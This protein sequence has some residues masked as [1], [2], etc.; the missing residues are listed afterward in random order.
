MTRGA[1]ATLR[2]APPRCPDATAPFGSVERGR[3][4]DKGGLAMTEHPNVQLMRDVYA[5]FTVGDLAKAGSYW[6]D[7]CTHH[8]P[9]RSQLAG[10]HKGVAEATAFATKLFELTGGNIQMDIVDIGASDDY[11]FAVVHTRYGRNGKTLDMPFINVARV[12]GGKIAEFWT[13]P[14]DQYAVDEFW[15]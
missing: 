13:Y 12:Q 10:S 14:Q 7:D 4:N 6:T 11:A 8:Y 15:S 5:A 9:G 3:A 1:R 2:G